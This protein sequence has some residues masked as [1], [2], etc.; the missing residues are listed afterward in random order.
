[1]SLLIS[2][3][4]AAASIIPGFKDDPQGLFAGGN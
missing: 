3:I 4:V 2:M 1:M